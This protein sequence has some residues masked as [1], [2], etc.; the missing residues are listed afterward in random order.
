[1]LHTSLRA[2]AQPMQG[3]SGMSTFQN[4]AP[5]GPTLGPRGSPW[6][7]PSKTKLTLS[8]HAAGAKFHWGLYARH[9]ATR[10]HRV[11]CGDWPVPWKLCTTSFICALLLTLAL[12]RHA[13]QTPCIKSLF[14]RVFCFLQKSRGPWE[15]V[16][17]LDPILTP[18]PVSPVAQLRAPRARQ[19]DPRHG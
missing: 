3:A 2:G 15:V 10:Q 19:P 13:P 5:G 1:M 17:T 6:F 8:I 16:P 11:V 9:R 7:G 18:Q 12:A 4:R 14:S